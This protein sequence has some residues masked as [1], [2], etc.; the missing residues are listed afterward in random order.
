[1]N[2]PE[3]HSALAVDK[4]PSYKKPQ[5]FVVIKYYD[6]SLSEIRVC[7]ETHKLLWGKAALYNPKPKQLLNTHLSSPVSL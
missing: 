1:V 3:Y 5:Q 7:T 2:I 6:G 4:N